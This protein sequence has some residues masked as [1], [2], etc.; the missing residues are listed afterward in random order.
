MTT[1]LFQNI[2]LAVKAVVSLDDAASHHLARVLRA[3]LKETVILF[4]GEGGE[5]EGIISIIEKKSVQV[6][7]TAFH[8]R[9]AESSLDICLLQGISRGEK[10]DYTL[11]KSVELGVKQIVPLLTERCNI[12]RESSHFE[13]KVRHWQQIIISACEQCGRNR[14]PTLTM[15]QTLEDF[16]NIQQPFDHAFVLAPTA[17]G[18]LK[19]H[20]IPPHARIA[21]L[22]GPEGGLS[23]AEIQLAATKNYLPLGL[24]PRIL[25]T[26]TA[27][28]AAITM[29]QCIAGDMC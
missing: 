3:Q 7:L 21:L 24:G 2:P 12:K 4:N 20:A 19:A 1:R 8:P 23:N 13:K 9:E 14:I 17:T 29:L 22:I 5:Y 16:L 25:R 26:E 10:M 15:P 28:L 11:Q 6:T 18:T 27:A